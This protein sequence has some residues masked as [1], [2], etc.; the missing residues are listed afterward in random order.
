MPN[1]NELFTRQ[2]VATMTQLS[3]KTFANWASMVPPKG[4]PFVKIG[5]KCR[6]PAKAFRAWQ[7]E[8][9]MMAA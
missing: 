7:A 4:P 3:T 5:G 9:P 6:Y 1:D 2:Q 8:Q